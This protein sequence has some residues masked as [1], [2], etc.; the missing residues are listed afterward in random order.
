METTYGEMKAEKIPD[1]T[2]TNR[3][4]K[5]LCV[6]KWAGLTTSI[7]PVPPVQTL[8]VWLILSQCEGAEVRRSWWFRLRVNG[9]P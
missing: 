6:G 3:V 5:R 1:E 9:V 7:L 2:Q 4:I 8:A